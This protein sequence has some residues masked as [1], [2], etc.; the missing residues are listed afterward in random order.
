[1]HTWVADAAQIV[2]S[3]YLLH[4]PT[5][6]ARTWQSWLTAWGTLQRFRSSER[7]DVMACIEAALL[8]LGGNALSE[9]NTFLNN[10]VHI[11]LSKSDQTSEITR[12]FSPLDGL[13]LCSQC[14]TGY[15]HDE[16][17]S[18]LSNLPDPGK[19]EFVV[20]GHAAFGNPTDP[21]S[22]ASGQTLML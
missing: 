21:I 1:M 11:Y 19:V 12:T 10:S 13:T 4:E 9:I 16:Q 3:S 15:Q 22:A 14:D 2:N 7:N 5:R 8:L 18:S 6:T 17:G 20:D